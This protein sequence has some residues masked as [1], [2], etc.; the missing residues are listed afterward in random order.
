MD[1]RG[2]ILFINSFNDKKD[3]TISIVDYGN[4]D[5]WKKSLKWDIGIKELAQLIKNFSFGNKTLRR[6]YYGED[7]GPNEKSSVLVDWSR[8]ILEK[9]RNYGFEMCTKRVKYIYEKNNVCGFEKKCDL[10]VEMTID[11]VKYRDSY[12]TV[13]LFSGDGDLMHAIKYLHEEYDKQCY[14]F[15]ARDHVGREVFDAKTA[16]LVRDVIFIEDFEYRLNKDRFKNRAY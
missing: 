7:Y 12:D 13:V 11:L 1:R 5:K 14:V 2:I 10:D 15:G 3:R 16:G 4:V 8:L 6:F 9:A